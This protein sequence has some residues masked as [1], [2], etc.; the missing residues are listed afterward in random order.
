MSFGL[1][2]DLAYTGSSSACHTARGW[3]GVS[4]FG[5]ALIS[6]T[7]IFVEHA[8]EHPSPVEVG[9]VSQEYEVCR[10]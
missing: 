6:F 2:V 9:G 3:S 8:R 10:S 1:T 4:W 5:K 7:Y